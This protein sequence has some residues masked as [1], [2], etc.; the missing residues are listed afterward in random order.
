MSGVKWYR[1]IIAAAA[2]RS[3]SGHTSRGPRRGAAPV[4]LGAILSA[5]GPGRAVSTVLVGGR[6]TAPG[7]HGDE[8]ARPPTLTH[9]ALHRAAPG[10][11]N[12]QYIENW[13]LNLDLIIPLKTV[14]ATFD[15]RTG[16]QPHSLQQSCRLAPIEL[17]SSTKGSHCLP[18]R[19]ISFLLLF[20]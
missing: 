17:L 3:T 7:A 5:P 15:R 16:Y 6:R 11:C 14:C 20:T 10:W 18:S 9:P 2:T 13:S 12:R 4:P 8:Y 1:K 19:W